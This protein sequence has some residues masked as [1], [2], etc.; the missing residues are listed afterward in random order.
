MDHL[1]YRLVK[2]DFGEDVLVHVD[3]KEHRL[4][5]TDP[6]DD[7]VVHVYYVKYSVWLRMTLE[8]AS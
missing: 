6:E 4:V 5:T 7:V 1:K 2:N 3:C 8:R